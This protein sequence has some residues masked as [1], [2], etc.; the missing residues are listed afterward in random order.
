MK[1]INGMS[2]LSLIITLKRCASGEDKHEDKT[3][4]F[5]ENLCSRERCFVST[6]KGI[7]HVIISGGKR[8]EVIHGKKSLEKVPPKIKERGE[9]KKRNVILEYKH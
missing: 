5:G 9:K 2:F 3:V 4:T 1:S 8:V 7:Y 6:C